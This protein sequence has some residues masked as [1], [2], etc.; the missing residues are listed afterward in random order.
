V[1]LTL[2]AVLLSVLVSGTAKHN[3]MVNNLVQELQ[4]LEIV[5]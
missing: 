5:E 2:C 3:H 4:R 1:M